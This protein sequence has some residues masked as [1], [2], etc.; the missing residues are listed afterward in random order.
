M[1]TPYN[2]VSRDAAAALE[3]FSSE[4]DKALAVAEP[5]NLWAKELGLFAESMA[6]RTTYPIPVSAAGYVKR[7][8]DDKLRRLFERSLHLVPEEYVDGVAELAMI[9]RAP[10]FIGWGEEPQRIATETLRFANT[11]VAAMLAANPTLDFYRDEKLHTD[12][13]IALFAG[14]HPVNIFDTSFGTFDNDHAAS[15]IDTAMMAASKQRFRKI[16]GPNGK[17]MG[18]RATH[19]LA[20]AAR[21]EEARDFLESDLLLQAVQE[22]G[23]NVGGATV[24]NRYKGAVTLVVADELADD[25]V[26]YMIAANGPKPWIYQ[27]QGDPEEIRYDEDS[28][29]YKDESKLGVKYIL[30]AGLAACLPH[31][32]ERITLS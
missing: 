7:K 1:A 28:E 17:P 20:P 3:E 18:L 30:R 22:A 24:S 27:E 5:D 15:A 19:M 32:I 2:M 12:L 9:I 6:M 26:I 31:A 29:M 23:A 13:N 21:E 8:G 10:D 16:K 4:F 25:D 14:N 11:A